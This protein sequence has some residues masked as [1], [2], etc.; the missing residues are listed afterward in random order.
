MA[1]RGVFSEPTG[2]R[3][4][5]IRRGVLA[6]WTITTLLGLGVIV[7]ILVP[8]IVPI[9]NWRSARR[10]LSPRLPQLNATRAQRE[11]AAKRQRLY[12]ALRANPAPPAF[13][14]SQFRLKPAA[15]TSKRSPRA[16]DAP[17]TAGFYVNW[18]DNS[19]TS[20]KANIGKLDWVI[21]EW[22]SVSPGGDSVRLQ[23]DHRALYLATRIPDSIRPRFF[24]MLSNVDSSGIPSSEQRVL[25]LFT[26]PARSRAI[27]LLG[28]AVVDSGMAGVTV[29]IEGVP[30]RAKGPFLN[31]V[32]ALHARLRPERKLLTMAVGVDVTD[33]DL[34]DFG[35]ATD[36]LILMDYDEHEAKSDPGPVASNDW[37]AAQVARA[38]RILPASSLI[39][40]VGAYGYDWNDI[41]GSTV[42]ELTFG[43]AMTRSRDNGTP[44]KFDTR[45]GNPYV[46][47]T[48]PDSTD[49]VGWFLDA[50]T[51]YNQIRSTR[52]LGTAGTAVWRLGAEDPALWQV[53]GR[54]GALGTPERL[55]TIPPGY[56]VEFDGSGEVLRVSAVPTVGHRTL[57]ASRGVG[58]IISESYSVLPSPFVVQRSGARRNHVALTFD[59]GPD[60][61][62]TPMILDTLRSRSAQGTFFVIGQ[63]VEGHIPLL[64]RIYRE[65]HEI[66]NHTFTHPNLALTSRFITRLEIDATERLI[67]AVLNRRSAF[68][69]PP[70]FGDAEPTTSDELVPVGIASD[71]GFLTAGL[72]ID[73]EDWT[74]PGAARIIA[75]V[76]QRR[77][78]GN[79]ILMHDGGGN[80]AQTVASLG[81][82]IDSLR[83][84]GDTLVLLSEL[85]NVSRDV[86]MPAL[87]PKST[88]ARLVELTSFGLLGVTEWVLHWFFLVAIFLGIGRVIIMTALAYAHEARSRRQRTVRGRMAPYHPSLSVVVP[89]YNEEKVVVATVQ[90]LLES[91]YEGPLEIIVVDDGSPDR[92]AEVARDTFAAEPR[93]VV[94]RKQNGGKATALNYGIA[95]ARGEIVLGLD[96]DT[97]FARNTVHDLV[98]PLAD[99]RVGAV[100]GNAKV[101]NR[102][103]LVTRFQAVE[104][105]TSQNLDRRAL[106]LVN[107]ITVVPG[108]VG[109]WRKSLVLELGGFLDDTLT[110]D[111]DL[112]I[113]VLRSGAKVEYV[114][115]AVA[116]TEAPDTLHG[117]AK[118]RFRWSFG[119]LQC[120]WKHRDAL[121]RPRYGALGWFAFPTVWVFQLLFPAVSPVADLLF[122]WSLA[123][124]WLV[125]MQHG[126]TYAVSNLH[127]LMILY[128]LFLLIDW[129]GS[130]LAFLL[131]RGE[132]L[133]LTLLVFLQRF[134]YR[135]LMYGVVVRSFV[136][137]LR[138]HLVG[139]GKLE[140]K[141]TVG[142]PAPARHPAP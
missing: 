108:A 51:A 44:I 128:A 37:F 73:S 20:L 17:V 141:A 30:G 74:E 55:D 122:L 13:R 4:R 32:R 66:G 14:P 113:R 71:L 124:I 80:R 8:P 85:V 106:A 16:P 31:F 57:T 2:R 137:A 133:A 100:A 42:D 99:P 56:D 138:G 9:L 5:R 54:H 111:Q 12:A 126:G 77:D 142:L 41:P 86:A 117:L 59:D 134:V 140:R 46:T 39:V 105:V 19:L 43:D 3:W 83:A 82:L 48:D 91:G 36:R 97:V 81:P 60:G 135:Q 70:Y 131:E 40:A 121:L 29:D 47:W 109:A 115:T 95:R 68:F 130:I 89:A 28:R 76:L 61:N 65:G 72:H 52:T 132:P 23:I 107:G 15:A 136:A 123:S 96:A 67:E 88:L 79:V 26:E 38:R 69:R 101:G 118:Q 50:V 75:N 127:Q 104:Y 98:Q 53:L 90:S 94:Y 139:W 129:I 7:A 33:A 34:R 10:V 116:Y 35:A 6:T 92:T 119:T 45:S 112:T 18:D 125:R 78:S 120:A 24:L 58:P 63:N 27:D 103:N 114:D 64:R 25:R 93:V 11:L 84:H 110:E 49:H 102:I 62:W 1:T 22:A 87:P 21:G